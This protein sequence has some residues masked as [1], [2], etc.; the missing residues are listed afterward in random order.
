MDWPVWVRGHPGWPAPHLIRANTPITRGPGT[1][2]DIAVTLALG[3]MAAY[4]DDLRFAH[5]LADAADAIS[6]RQFRS[7]DL[8][9][10]TKPDLTPVTEADRSV[11]E[12]LR[13]TLRYPPGSPQCPPGES[14][15]AAKIADCAPDLATEITDLNWE[16]ALSFF[17]A[18]LPGPDDG[19]PAESGR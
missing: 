8:H 4:D 6:L 3:A 9:V 11:E 5:V 13:S 7:L 15:L 19:Q 16:D 14:D 17:E 2:P 1:I 10:D 18:R 12:V